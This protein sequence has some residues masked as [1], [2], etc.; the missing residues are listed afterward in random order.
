[1]KI[2]YIRVSTVKQATQG[3][4]LETQE[5]ALK[6]AGC[7]RLY[8]DR[9]KSGASVDRPELTRMRSSLREGDEVVVSKLDRFGRNLRDTLALI[10]EFTQAGVGF[11]SLAEGI[12]TDNSPTGKLMLNVF[13]SFAEF[14]RDRIAERTAEGIEKAKQAGKKF[15]RPEA[16][17]TEQIQKLSEIEFKYPRMTVSEKAKQLD[18]SVATYHRIRRAREALALTP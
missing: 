3:T 15:G 9:G 14:E 17:H 1:M 8:I 16:D 7:E 13:A 10:D 12:K 11:S 4:S 5:E 6:A 18:V 2:G